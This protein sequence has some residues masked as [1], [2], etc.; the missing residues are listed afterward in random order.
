MTS[1][2][3]RRRP[4]GV[5]TAALA[6]LLVLPA[7]GSKKEDTGPG[8]PAAWADSM[9]SALTTWRTSITNAGNSLQG[10]QTFSKAKVEEAANKVS[11]ANDTL[12][13][14]LKALGKPPTQGSSEAKIKDAAKGVSS[15]SDAMQAL[16]VVSETFLKMGSDITATFTTLESLNATDEWKRAFADSQACQSLKKS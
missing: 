1:P 6:V 9:C 4:D 14:D 12:A 10:S 5:A 3:F 8:T 16:P 2:W 7:C 11:A 15:A 13:S